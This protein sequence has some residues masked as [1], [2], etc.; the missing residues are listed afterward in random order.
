MARQMQARVTSNA[1]IMS[2]PHEHQAYKGSR[3]DDLWEVT[4]HLETVLNC[5]SGHAIFTLDEAG[6]VTSWN[7]G[8]E[9]TN[10]YLKDDILG[11]N[12]SCFY[13]KADQ[14]DGV[15]L[16]V[17]R[18]AAETGK[19]EA[20]GWRV[21]KNG[22][23]FWA[24][25]VIHPL[26]GFSGK[27]RGFVEVTRDITQRLQID[28]LREELNQSQ[29][30]ELVGQLTGGVAHD[31]NNFL[32]AIEAGHDLILNYSDEPRIARVMEINKVATER[33]RKLVSQLLAFSRR[34]VLNPKRSTVWAIVSALDVL[35]QKAVGEQVQLRWNLQPDLPPVLVDQGQFQSV[36]LN[37]VVNARDA[38]PDGGWLTVFM[39]KLALSDS[40]YPAPY[41]LPAGDYVVLG[42]SDTGTGMSD[43]VRDRAIE[44]F[45]TTKDV[46]RGTG[47]GLSQSFG[48]ARQS[49]GTLRIESM[50]GRGTTVRILLPAI[51]VAAAT[52]I[53][54]RQKTILF[55]D[56]DSAIRT[57][58][59]EMLR[60]LGHKVIEAE[61]GREALALLEK[62]RTINF[63][64]SDIV[65][66]NHMNGLELM[67]A[68]RLARPGLP[69]L[70]ASGYPREV[71]R[72][73]GDIPEDVCFI[74]K[75]Y[76]LADISAHV[77]GRCTMQ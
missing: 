1:L 22:E 52:N 44:P 58:V 54:P 73:L 20:E 9:R 4:E 28:N 40:N 18:L 16:R 42:V 64:F 76:S 24:N 47:L 34:Q 37:L 29:K 51:D 72:D 19:H 46:G 5:L 49:G 17:L 21:R 48:F 32:T 67:N 65:M 11:Q 38:M 14:E 30:L 68:A 7:N 59:C 56:D 55:V 66:P 74:P 77:G 63:L 62:D 70:L 13:T 23:K 10:G 8:A 6:N 39:E 12:F 43:D 3:P 50:L 60:C 26:T 36:L 57:L 69:T 75:P 2:V 53:V 61:D 33:S 27:I 15:P 45:F 71:L 31:F 41:D 35:I 25:V